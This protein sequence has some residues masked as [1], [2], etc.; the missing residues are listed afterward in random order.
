MLLFIGGEQLYPMASVNKIMRF[1]GS[2]NTSTDSVFHLLN[3]TCFSW[4]IEL[5]FSAKSGWNLLKQLHSMMQLPNMLILT[6]KLILLIQWIVKLLA[7]ASN[8][9][10]VNRFSK[11]TTMASKEDINVFHRT[12]KEL[13]VLLD[14]KITFILLLQISLG[15]TWQLLR[16]VGPKL[17]E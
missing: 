14:Q 5:L 3:K 13:N 9:I 4:G 11:F 17:Y 7:V 1:I 16:S 10:Y 12:F 6:L 2:C 15:Y 8:N